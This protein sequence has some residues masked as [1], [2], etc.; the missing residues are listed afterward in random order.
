MCGFM[1]FVSNLNEIL[2]I[3]RICEKKWILIRIY[4]WNISWD[5]MIFGTDENFP[6]NFMLTL[7]EP[8][9]RNYRLSVNSGNL[10]FESNKC[11]QVLVGIVPLGSDLWIRIREARML[12]IPSIVFKWLRLVICSVLDLEFW[13][14]E[15]LVNFMVHFLIF[16]VTDLFKLFFI[17][18]FKIRLD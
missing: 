2:Q 6:I 9:K 15:I 16:Q 12:Q 13:F 17:L 14:L 8:F 11:L 7:H 4:V 18:F 1:Q 10:C 3:G 5:L